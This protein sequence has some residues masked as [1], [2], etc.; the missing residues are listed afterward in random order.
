MSRSP[1]SPRR[2]PRGLPRG[3]RRRAADA[4]RGWFESAR[5][6]VGRLLQASLQQVLEGQ[7]TDFLG[8]GPGERTRS[9]AGRRNGHRERS[10]RTSFGALPLLQPRDRAR[11][12]SSALFDRYPQVEG[13]VLDTLASMHL[14]GVSGAR[15]RQLAVTLCGHPLAPAAIAQIAAGIGAALERFGDAPIAPSASGL[16]LALRRTRRRIDG[17]VR[18][19]TLLTVERFDAKGRSELVSVAPAGRRFSVARPHV[20]QRLREA[21]RRGATIAVVG[22]GPALMGLARP[23]LRLTPRRGTPR[24]RIALRASCATTLPLVAPDVAGFA[25]SLSPATASEPTQAPGSID[26]DPAALPLTASDRVSPGSAPAPGPAFARRST[27]IDAPAADDAADVVWI[28]RGVEHAIG[29]TPLRTTGQG[30]PRSPLRLAGLALGTGLV[31]LTAWSFAALQT[32]GDDAPRERRAAAP[33]IPVDAPRPQTART[34]A[35][36][37]ANLVAAAPHDE[38]PATLRLIGVIAAKAA[39]GPGIALI[40][41]G[42]GAAAPYRVGAQVDGDLVLKTVSLDRAELGPALGPA[43][44]VLDLVAAP[45]MRAAA[46]APRESAGHATPRPDEA[47]VAALPSAPSNGGER[48]DDL[49]VASASPSSAVVDPARQSAVKDASAANA[50]RVTARRARVRGHGTSP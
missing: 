40:A 35:S 42:S 2:A 15:V 20:L 36:L 50:A 34:A 9:R 12:F 30:R 45:A 23:G 13:T 11:Q 46:D 5:P 17:V 49:L 31:A 4:Q 16:A 48:R 24:H 27:D 47:A 41:I 25:A 38:P 33:A 10:L 19:V 39:D 6:A 28:H 18:F 21:A 14:R 26:R 8:A 29:A 32:G 3:G 1:A 37:F 43:T 22:D 7:M 44:R